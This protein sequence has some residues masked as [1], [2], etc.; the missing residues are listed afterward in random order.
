MSYIKFDVLDATPAMSD[1]P[2]DIWR[3][4][5]LSNSR[6]ST[7]FRGCGCMDSGTKGES[8]V[9][10]RYVDDNIRSIKTREIDQLLAK[11]NQLLP[12]LRFTIER[13]VEKKIPFLDMEIS[14]R[15]DRMST[16][17]YTKRVAVNRSNFSGRKD[18]GR[19]F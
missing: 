17:W 6:K 12:N 16:S 7:M 1:R 11:T 5:P 14:K 15:D 3:Q 8:K 13:C 19:T 10:A 18:R 2:S 9:F 4:V